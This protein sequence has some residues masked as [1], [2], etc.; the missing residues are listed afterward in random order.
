MLANPA[1]PVTRIPRLH[2]ISEQELLGLLPQQQADGQP[3]ADANPLPPAAANNN[4]NTTARS[5]PRSPRFR[6][7]T[8]AAVAALRQHQ[9][10]T[11]AA[12]STSPGGGEP[13]PAPAA[14]LQAGTA[15]KELARAAEKAFST[16]LNDWHL[17]PLHDIAPIFQQRLL[18]GPIGPETLATH[19]GLSAETCLGLYGLLHRHTAGFQS[20]AARLVSGALHREQLLA[21]LWR[22]FAQ[23]WDDTVQCSFEGEVASAVSELQLTYEA[24]SDTQDSLDAALRENGALRAR[25]NEFVRSNLENMLSFRALKA[26]ADSLEGACVMG[27]GTW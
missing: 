13:A 23:L 6:S 2:G 19:H 17:Q 27:G 12:R 8:P 16:G 15:I 22:A 10:V 7:N 9:L 24:L 4:N 18:V 11:A 1:Q 14:V 20:E 26:K 5:S 21:G 3:A 25:C